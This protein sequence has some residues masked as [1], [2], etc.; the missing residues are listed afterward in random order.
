MIKPNFK[1]RA[2][3]P[4]K[5][6]SNKTMFNLQDYDKSNPNAKRYLTVFCSND[7]EIQDREDIV[8]EE[9][10]SITLGEY[11]SKLQVSI[12]AKVR[13]DSTAVD[14]HLKEMA[15]NVIADISNDDIPF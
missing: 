14:K 4:K 12:W 9:I 2:Y 7:I 15:G 10:E 6:K 13:L 11:Q 5:T 3:S 1:Y 8:L